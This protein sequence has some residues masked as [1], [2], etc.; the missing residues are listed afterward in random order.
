MQ[1]FSRLSANV[2]VLS[3]VPHAPTFALFNKQRERL[4]GASAVKGAWL[5]NWHN[6]GK[7]IQNLTWRRAQNAEPSG[8]I[9]PVLQKIRFIRHLGYS[10]RHFVCCKSQKHF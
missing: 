6:T 1:Q 9:P 10:I 8:P 3:V 2:T 7:F 5:L 4:F